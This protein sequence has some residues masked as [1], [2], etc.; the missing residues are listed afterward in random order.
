MNPGQ[1]SC[2]FLQQ[3]L[4]YDY[5]KFRCLVYRTGIQKLVGGFNP[6]DKIKLGIISPNICQQKSKIFEKPSPPEKINNC[7]LLYR[8]GIEIFLI[9]SVIQ[10]S[11]GPWQ[12]MPGV[13]RIA[14]VSERNKGEIN[15]QFNFENGYF[16]WI[17]P[18]Y[19]ISPT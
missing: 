5:F 18:N 15:V 14:F 12:P 6:A 19:N 4:I 1:F 10:K 7:S 17:W 9:H 13:Q 3:I 16:K 2:L 11:S 8:T